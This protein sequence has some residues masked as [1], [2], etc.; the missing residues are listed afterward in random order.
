MGAAHGINVATIQAYREGI[1]TTTNVIVPGPWSPEAMRLLRENPDL[2]AGVHLAITSEWENVKW[3]PLTDA[4]SL[5]DPD[6]YFFT[7]VRP[8][9]G[10]PPKTSVAEASPDLDDVEREVRAQIE[11][12]KRHVPQLTYTWA[13]MGF[14]SLSPEIRDIVARLSRE[15]GLIMPGRDTGLQFLGRVYEQLDSGDAK[16]EKLA[17]RLEE[18]GPGTWITVDHAAI[19]SPEVQAIG[20]KGYEQVAADRSAVLAAWTSPKVREVIERRGIELTNYRKLDLEP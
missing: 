14:T 10:F 7:M 19:D 16:A 3:R 8:R 9:E 1:L 4:R 2:D 20:H 13:H 15:H 12:A 11:T 6:G 5:T 17:A 18:I